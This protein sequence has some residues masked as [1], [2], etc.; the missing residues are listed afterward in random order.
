MNIHVSINE[1][2]D[3]FIWDFLTFPIECPSM[4]GREND[5]PLFTG[6]VIKAGLLTH[7]H[8][9]FR[10]HKPNRFAGKRLNGLCAATAAG[11]V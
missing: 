8:I 4:T 10:R 9:R 2:M 6:D 11:P 7:Y 1:R 3:F 5:E